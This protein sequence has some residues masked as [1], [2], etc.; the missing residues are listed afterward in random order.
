MRRG[1]PEV[2]RSPAPIPDVVA[3][4][5]QVARNPPGKSPCWR[6]TVPP[7]SRV[8]QF[9]QPSLLNGLTGTSLAPPVSH[10][11]KFRAMTVCVTL[12]LFLPRSIQMCCRPRRAVVVA[13]SF[14][15]PARQLRR[16]SPRR[17]RRRSG[18]RQSP[19]IIRR[20]SSGFHERQN[21]M[22]AVCSP[23]A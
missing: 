23:G 7:S 1:R 16:E 22:F 12:G 13:E 14:S 5:V 18:R 17:P 19:E 11:S 6:I 9:L 3:R 15:E 10:S 2:R 4:R 8:Q 21:T 20:R